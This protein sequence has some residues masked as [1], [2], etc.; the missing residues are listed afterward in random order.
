MGDPYGDRSYVVRFADD[1]Q[2]LGAGKKNH[3]TIAP[4]V[5]RRTVAP[6][7][8]RRLQHGATNIGRRMGNVH[9]EDDMA[10]FRVEPD[11]HAEQT[12]VSEHCALIIHNHEK[13]EVVSGFDDGP[14][15]TLEVVD[16]VVAYTDPSTGDKWMLVLNQCLLV[17]GIQHVLLSSNQV[18]MNDIR[19]NDE[20]KHLVL[21]PTV[22]H[23][24]IAAKT[25]DSN[26][27][28]EELIIPMALSGVFSYFEARKPTLE[29]WTEAHSD[30]C[31]PLTYDAP[32]WEPRELELNEQES[33]MIDAGWIDCGTGHWYL[34]PSKCQP[35]DCIL[36]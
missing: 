20:P 8:L 10:V 34:E 16:A 15:K 17:P 24:A 31:I 35:H 32:E 22:Y 18:R 30:W 12:C 25:P 9:R 6:V 13:T 28:V 27:Q 3:R 26:E 5:H 4:K 11:S 14:G 2:F 1:V 29:Q 23:H 21:N 33:A 7:V 19:V 36:V